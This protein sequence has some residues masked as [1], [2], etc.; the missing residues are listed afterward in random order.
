MGNVV[1]AMTLAFACLMLAPGPLAQDATNQP[2]VVLK[3]STRL[4]QVSVLAT[5]HG[6]PVNGLTRADFTITDNGR[7]RDLATFSEESRPAA[8][9]EAAPN[10]STSPR[11]AADVFA[12][13][14]PIAAGRR[15]AVNIILLDALNTT[16]IREEIARDAILQ[17]LKTMP[18]EDHIGIYLLGYRLEVIHDCTADG[19]DAA[20]HVRGF[21]HQNVRHRRPIASTE[22]NFARM[23]TTFEA[24]T[25]IANHLA[26]LPGRKNLIWISSGFPPEL[27]FNGQC[28]ATFAGSLLERCI[29]ALNR[30][31]VAIYPIDASGLTAPPRSEASLSG[32]GSVQKEWNPVIIPLAPQVR[33]TMTTMADATGGRA[34]VNTNDFARAIRSSVADAETSY[35][36]GYYADAKA[37]GKFH[38]ISVSVKQGGI[39]LR[40][41][42]GYFDRAETPA[43]EAD[44][45]AQLQT[46]ATSP[47]EST[48]L[49]VT[50]KV[51]RTADG[52]QLTVHV[53]P[54]GISLAEKDSR[55]TGQLDVVFV[56]LDHDGKQ[57][58]GRNDTLDLKLT[59]ERYQSVVAHGFSY[60]QRVP[61][62]SSASELRVM[63][64]DNPSG[65]I[66]SVAI[67]LEEK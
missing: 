29:A 18:P 48:E 55:W 33:D 13:R 36:L 31:N 49:G 4:V 19:R 66:G 28:A 46:V 67:P 5:R 38:Q 41:R 60:R 6:K 9:P 56:Q 1:M 21:W 17:Y 14:G 45:K 62:A 42:R 59:A 22:Q 37:D 25:N 44:Q 27:C 53:D 61:R 30:A 52:L 34:W 23:R 26:A 39:E 3:S 64:R 12:N 54:D 65:A 43:D 10:L 11:R 15:S 63:V 16:G 35:T 47:L 32:F 2:P 24:L 40:H 50:V 58:H 20:E 51:D 57:Q 8:G 7:A